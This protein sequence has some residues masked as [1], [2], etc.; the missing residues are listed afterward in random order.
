MEPDDG[1]EGLPWVWEDRLSCWGRQGAKMMVGRNSWHEWW[2]LE[3]TAAGAART[4][5]V[6]WWLARQGK[7][8]NRW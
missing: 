7:P 3:A 6:G 4:R 5:I 2:G 1:E 8:D